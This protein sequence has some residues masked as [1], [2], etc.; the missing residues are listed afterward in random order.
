MKKIL[1]VSFSPRGKASESFRLSQRIVDQLIQREPDAQV[2]ERDLGSGSIAH[3]DGNYAV[4]Q[5]GPTDVS[6]EGSMAFSEELIKD[7]ESADFVVIS[8]PMHNLSIPSSLKAW[9]DHV[10]RVRRTFNITPAGKI[11]TLGGRPVFVA[12]ASGGRFSGEQPNQPDFLTPYLSV[13]LGMIGLKDPAFFSVQGTG[14]AIPETL[15]E[16]R[17]K[18]EQELKRYFAAFGP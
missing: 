17:A 2:L 6:R 7:L 9:I 3:V 10:V 8:T 18:T 4:S 16:T 5:G 13:I 11:G 15:A 12:I 1:R 14:G